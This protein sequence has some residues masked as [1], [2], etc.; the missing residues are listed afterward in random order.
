MDLP[1]QNPDGIAIGD[2]NKDG[3]PDLAVTNF[4]ANSV[5]IFRNI[6]VPGSI[7]F[8]AR[9]DYPT[10]Q[11]PSGISIGDLDGD[12]WQDIIIS[13]D[14][15]NYLSIFKNN[16]IAGNISLTSINNLITGI[17]AKDVILTDIDG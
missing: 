17:D 14:N 9:T 10:G 1:A 7:S 11:Y 4:A 3:K 5:S 2:L 15:S 12:T 8:A 16:A 6:S 13:N